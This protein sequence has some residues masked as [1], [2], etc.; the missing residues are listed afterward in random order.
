MARLAGDE[1]PIRS[2]TLWM[3][4]CTADIEPLADLGNSYALVRDMRPVPFS[5]EDV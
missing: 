1:N 3:I 5:L 4:S 2:R